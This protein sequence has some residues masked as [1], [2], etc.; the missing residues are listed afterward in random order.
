MGWIILNRACSRPKA[1]R[2]PRPARGILGGIM[3]TSIIFTRAHAL[4]RAAIAEFAD[5]DYRATFAAALR[6]AWA[7]ALNDPRAEWESMS[8]EEQYSALIRS[9]WYGVN[10]D[11]AECDRMGNPRPNYFEWVACEDDA[12]AC[13]HGGWLN[14]ADA[15]TRAEDAVTTGKRDSMPPLRAIMMAAC[16][17]AARKTWRNEIKHNHALRTEAI[18]DSDGNEIK[19]EYIKD[20]PTTE[21][22]APNPEYALILRDSIDRACA[23]DMDMLIVNALADGYSMREIAE[24]V[25]MSH[26]AISKRVKRIRERY[27]GEDAAQA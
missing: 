20:A 4:T 6:I 5:A 24:R 15:L 1:E 14:M 13:A 27:R 25:G 2:P 9:V 18:R 23:D 7:D 11:R 3:K 22:I 12:R 8:G 17:N 16:R 10:R 26:P 21:H 19:R